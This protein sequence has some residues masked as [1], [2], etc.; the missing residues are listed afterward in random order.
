MTTV[1][2]QEAK[3]HLAQLLDRVA[4]GEKMLITRR[5]EP[6]ALLMPPPPDE[7][8]DI[9][10]VIEQLREYSKKQGRTLGGLT[11]RDLIDEGRRY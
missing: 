9:A 8:Q 10:K 1:S 6:A 5:G 11:F 4:K 3:S 2:T 7:D